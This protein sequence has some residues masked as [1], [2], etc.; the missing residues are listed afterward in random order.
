MTDEPCGC[1][2]TQECDRHYLDD[3]ARFERSQDV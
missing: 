1:T 3:D 2:P